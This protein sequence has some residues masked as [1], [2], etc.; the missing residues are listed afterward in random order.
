MSGSVRFRPSDK[1]IAVVIDIF[2]D[3]V[4]R[5]SDKRSVALFRK[6]RRQFS[7]RV[8]PF[9]FDFLRICSFI[10]AEGVP[11][12]LLYANGSRMIGAILGHEI[13]KFR[14]LLL[15]FAGKATINVVL[16][17]IPAARSL[18]NSVFIC[19]ESVRRPIR[20]RTG[21]EICCKGT[22]MYFAMPF[23]LA[24]RS[25]SSSVTSSG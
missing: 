15:R 12:S 7:E 18:P 1:H 16:I 25:M 17:A 20:L 10:R 14:E 19:A 9:E 8:H 4:K 22:S 2:I 5:L 6:P 3:D 11:F 23:S 13:H 21:S 24:M